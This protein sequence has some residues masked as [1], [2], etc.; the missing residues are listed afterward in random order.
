M[1]RPL[2]A[3][4]TRGG[5][6]L[7]RRRRAP[8]A[9]RYPATTPRDKRTR[10]GMVPHGEPTHGHGGPRGSETS[11]GGPAAKCPH[12]SAT[13]SIKNELLTGCIKLGRRPWQK[14]NA[15]T[16]GPQLSQHRRKT[17]KYTQRPVLPTQRKIR[18]PPNP[19]RRL[20]DP[21]RPRSRH[22]C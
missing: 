21:Q 3:N 18:S 2:G 7:R 16:H 19:Q 12:R 10:R 5:G 14:H 15:E 20:V 6:N 4:R 11:V 22:G 1:L 8:T 13:P 9:G 17:S